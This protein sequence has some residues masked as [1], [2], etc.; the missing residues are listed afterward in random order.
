MRGLFPTFYRLYRQSKR[1]SGITSAERRVASAIKVQRHY[2]S[3][4]KNCLHLSANPKMIK[5]IAF[6]IEHFF[7][8][9]NKEGIEQEKA[10]K[11]KLI[12]VTKKIDTI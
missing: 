1:D 8:Q 4:L 3:N 5:P 7:E 10:L 6:Q 11:E 12:E 2:T 9:M